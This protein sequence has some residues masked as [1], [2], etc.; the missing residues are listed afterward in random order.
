MMK[1]R[2]SRTS[3][4]P[5]NSALFRLHAFQKRKRRPPMERGTCQR[6]SGMRYTVKRLGLSH[7]K[8]QGGSEKLQLQPVSVNRSVFLLP[9]PYAHTHARHHHHLPSSTLH[10]SFFSL[11]SYS[12]HYV[13]SQFGCIV[14]DQQRSSGGEEESLSQLYIS[15]RFRTHL[16]EKRLPIPEFMT[17]KEEE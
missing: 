7:P 9:F 6:K 3:I 15:K 13:N 16:E 12:Y 11:P 8:E 14:A 5:P 17:H 1:G 4:A 10:P 2:L